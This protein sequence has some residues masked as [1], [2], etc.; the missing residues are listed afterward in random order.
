MIYAALKRL[1]KH[2]FIYALGPAVNKL[3]GFALLPFVTLWIGSTANYGVLEIGS[4]TIAIA[5]QV[6]GINL[7]HGMTRFHAHYDSE[8]E[9]GTLVTTTLILLACSTGSALL[10]AWVFR[11]PASE[12]VFESDQY[13]SALVVVFAI[14]FFQTIGQ[15]GLRWLQIL[16][17]SITYG[18]LTTVKLVLEIGLK[19]WLLLLGLTYMGAFYSVLGGEALIALV[20]FVVI[21]KKLGLR[22]SWP[23]AKRLF[24]YSAPL[25][26]SGL[27]MFVLHQADRFFVQRYAGEA[28]VGLYGLAYKLGTIGNAILLEG[29]GLIWFPFVFGLR[30]DDEARLLS[31]KVMTYFNLIMCALTLALAVFAREIVSAMAAPEFHSAWPALAI[32]ALGYL[33]WGLYQI[34]STVFYRHERTWVIGAIASAAAVFNLILNAIFVPRFGFMGA[35]WST[36]ATFAV[37]CVTAWITAERVAPIG[38][39]YRRILWPI[40]L[41]GGLYLLSWTVPDWPVPAVIALKAALVAALPLVLLLSGYLAREEKTKIKEIWRTLRSAR[42]VRSE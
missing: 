29:F 1:T 25:F 28:D 40:G 21:V 24:A 12:L 27:C 37:L 31:R 9:R 13:S 14:L 32:V 36:L 26:I 35:A 15:V 7:L 41:A 42:N 17:R 6:L 20:L 38:Y 34:V 3:L 23:M 5:A 18:V 2:S 30:S 10:L 19:V 39:E 16:E 33:F 11:G 22:F 8:R 4:V